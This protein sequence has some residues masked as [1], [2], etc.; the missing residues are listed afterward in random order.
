M[1]RP[2]PKW[3][4]RYIGAA[5]PQASTHLGTDELDAVRQALENMDAGVTVL[6]AAGRLLYANAAAARLVGY[7]SPSDLI[8]A[9]GPAAMARFD[10]VGIDGRPFAPE[11]LPSRLAFSG[12]STE[13]VIRFRPRGAGA[14]RWSRVRGVP[15]LD[16]SGKPVRVVTFFSDVTGQQQE[17]IQRQ[18]LLRAADEL[19]SSLDYE[20]TLQSV[21][22]LAVPALADWCAVDLLHGDELKRVATAHVDP[23]K[24]ALVSE[25]H[26]RW[27]SSRFST[28][29]G[30]D[31]IRTGKAQLVKQISQEML[32]AAAAD[33]AQLRVVEQLKLC[34]YI[35]VPLTAYD[36]PVGALIFATAESGRHY[37]ERDLRTAQTLASR[38]SLAIERARSYQEVDRSRSA[39]QESFRLMV[40]GV[41]DY[42][43]FRLDPRGI[44]STW[45]AGAQL[46]KGYRAEEIIGSHFSRF[47]RA[48]EVRAGK[49]ELEL[50]GSRTRAGGSARTGPSSGPTSSS[51]RS[52][53][54]KGKSPASSRS[55]AISRS[56]DGP[57]RNGRRGWRRNRPARPRTNFLRCSATS[58]AT[59]W[60]PS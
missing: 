44:V 18:F 48:E 40:E 31:I 21:A 34:S 50:E 6:D 17:E 27:P 24:L 2:C 30:R 16:A 43:I 10:L 59:R 51:P 12:R 56:E 3:D 29:G 36:R 7:D 41:K 20:K 60:P 14:D 35:G 53:T 52:S 11:Q 57:R 1:G 58:C 26:E 22:Q 38:V 47:Y 37:T 45:N 9:T 13:A 32:T 54:G 19:N 28:G 15:V 39:T 42:A 55:R 8:A 46:I 23:A 49:C 33:E 5:L 4:G 25:I